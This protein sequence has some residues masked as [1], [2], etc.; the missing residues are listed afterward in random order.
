MWRPTLGQGPVSPTMDG[1]QAPQDPTPM[2]GQEAPA[3]SLATRAFV[4]A[5]GGPWVLLAGEETG[6]L[7]PESPPLLGWSR[8]L[9]LPQALGL[10]SSDTPHFPLVAMVQAPPT[11]LTRN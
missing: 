10:L 5:G 9:F 4:G 1:P 2:S 11:S 7:G 8:G 6:L 3:W